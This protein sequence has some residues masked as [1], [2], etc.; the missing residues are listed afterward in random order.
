MFIKDEAALNCWV[1]AT[2]KNKDINRERSLCLNH[3]QHIFEWGVYQKPRLYS[4]ELFWY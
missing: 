3:H 4:V 2:L 1:G